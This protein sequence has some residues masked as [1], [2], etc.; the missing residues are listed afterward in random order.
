MNERE[1]IVAWLR[2]DGGRIPALAAFAP[3]VSGNRMP[4]MSGDARNRLHEPQRRDFNDVVL[5]LCAAI[6]RGEHLKG[7]SDER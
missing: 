4:D 3:L 6:E 5:S 7:K 1:A 2:G